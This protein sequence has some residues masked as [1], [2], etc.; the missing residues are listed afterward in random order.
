MKVYRK[1]DISVK[2]NASHHANTADK[3]TFFIALI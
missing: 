1:V 3:N 2:R